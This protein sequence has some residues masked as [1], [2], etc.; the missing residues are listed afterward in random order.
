MLKFKSPITSPEDIEF[1]DDFR[2]RLKQPYMYDG[3]G[4]NDRLKIVHAYG[5]VT[6]SIILANVESATPDVVKVYV[7]KLMQ[8]LYPTIRISDYQAPVDARI[9]VD[10]AVNNARA[11]YQK[12][13][14]AQ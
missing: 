2:D 5:Q 4:D 11:I 1:T 6:G 9:F 14:A 3:C 13:E 7:L 12:Q 8:D 10:A